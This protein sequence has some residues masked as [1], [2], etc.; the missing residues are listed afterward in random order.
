MAEA[1]LSALVSLADPFRLLMLFTG[2]LAGAVIG[3]LPGLGGIA[4]VSI[5]LPFIYGMDAHSGLAMLLGALGVVYT[6]DTITSVLVGTPGSPASA[7]TAI[8][9]YAMAQ[10]GEA[11]RALSA[12]FLSSMIG[13][14]IGALVLTLAI[15]VAGPLVLALGTPE[16]LMLA[17]VGLSYASGLVGRD[18][19]KGLASGALGLLLGMIGVAPA[20]AELRYTFGQAYLL[21][22]LSLVVVALGF[23]GVAEVV[24]MLGRGGAISQHEFKLAG[25]SM[26]ARDVLRNWG[27]AIKGALIGVTAGLIPAVGANASTWISYGHA[28]STTRDKSRVG[29]GEVRGIIASE[30]ANNATVAADL[31]PTM[32]FGVPGGPAAAIFLG[33]LFVYGYYP[34]PRFIQMHQDVMFLIIWS[35]AIAAVAGAALCFLISPYIARIT[36]LDFGLVAAPLLVVMLLGAYEATQVYA[37]FIVL[38]MFGIVGWLMKEGGWPRAPLL[39]GFVL[40]DPIERNFWLTNQLHGWTWLDRPIVILLA[41]LIVM[42][43]A[44]G[45]L[46]TLRARRAERSAPTARPAPM[47]NPQAAEPAPGPAGSRLDLNLLFAAAAAIL[48]G[49]ALWTAFDFRADSRLG[50]LLAA[51]PGLLAALAVLG[52]RLAGSGARASWPGRAEMLHFLLLAALVAAIRIVGFLPALSV[53]LLILL[54]VSTHLRLGALAYAAGLVGLAYGLM[55]LLDIRLA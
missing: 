23:F 54:L 48:F 52:R 11:G 42:P 53:Y 43:F 8:E 20:A 37:D 15:P 33:A 51:V 12:A 29:R 1:A 46:R 10:Q 34:G 14:L 9:G 38:V 3:M 32:L 50:P 4:A 49:Y 5:L 2:M 45:G 17:I 55:Q 35:T 27:L 6:A 47:D 40:S 7:P 41:L 18:R 25:W 44:L 31:V 21:E 13:G 36:R 22:G 19:A 24:S 26:G 30:G 28:V 39:V 16:L